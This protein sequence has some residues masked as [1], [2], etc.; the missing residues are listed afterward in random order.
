[1]VSKVEPSSLLGTLSIIVSKEDDIALIQ[2]AI[3]SELT[4]NPFCPVVADLFVPLLQKAKKGD[5]EALK[6]AVQIAL[7][8]FAPKR[9]I[10]SIFRRR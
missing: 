8:S 6:M 4:E 2:R 5:E 3:Q 1:M 9:S 10:F 7:D